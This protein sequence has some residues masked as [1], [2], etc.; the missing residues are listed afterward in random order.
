M[1]LKVIHFVL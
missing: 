1:I